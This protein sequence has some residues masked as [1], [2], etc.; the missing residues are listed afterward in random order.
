MRRQIVLLASLM[1]AIA[2]MCSTFP[3]AAQTVR[4][5][6]KP[7][8]VNFKDVPIQNALDILF[9]GTGLNKVIEPGVRGTVNLTLVDVPFSDALSAITKAAGM[10]VRKEKGIYYI[11]PQKEYTPESVASDITVP[12]I[13]KAK[14]LEKIP[15]GY[16]DVYDIGYVFG[17]QPISSRASSMTGS[18]SGGGFGG[19][20]NSSFG[21]NNN[22]NS[23]SNFGSGSN[24]RSSG[25]SSGTSSGSTG[26]FGGGSMG[27]SSGGGLPSGGGGG[28]GGGL[29]M[30]R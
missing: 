26:G 17:V 10:T 30:P 29:P 28:T 8:S 24:N 6:E 18:G 16:A 9:Q 20:S 13:E 5:T 15:I 3:A 1:L 14:I 19:N 27:G 11:G 21:G 4:E 23:N 12:E 7:I 2:I 22:S 25:G